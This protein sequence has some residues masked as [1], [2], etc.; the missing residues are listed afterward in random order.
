MTLRDGISE[1]AIERRLGSRPALAPSAGHRSRVLAAVREVLESRPLAEAVGRH[2]LG[3]GGVLALAGMA[4]AIAPLLVG[5]WWLSLAAVAGGSAWFRSPRP[6]LIAHARMVGVELPPD[7]LAAVGPE[8]AN[9]E[10]RHRTHPTA[11]DRTSPSPGQAA[12]RWLRMRHTLV[13][14]L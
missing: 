7:A 4:A 2:R 6:S 1:R 14:E 10:R 3:G 11:V 8:A 9:G 12:E 13:R 5:P